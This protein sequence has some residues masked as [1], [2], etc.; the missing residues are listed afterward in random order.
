MDEIKDVLK[1]Y[2]KPFIQESLHS[3]SVERINDFAFVF[4]KDVAEIYD[5]I[6]RIR[7]TKRN[8]TGFSLDDAP[9][10]GPLVR[11]WKLLKEVIRYYEAKNAEIIS[12]LERPLIEAA[13]VAEYLLKSD[14][15]VIEDY[16]KCSYKDRLRMMRDLES[17]SR[18]YETK[19][20]KRL[21]SSVG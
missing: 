8:P 11:I 1:K 19:A 4:A 9:I 10:L 13:V 3:G 12:I 15:S 14:V 20:G 18:F 2:N 21:L 16:R 5:A 17:G 7:N 6:T